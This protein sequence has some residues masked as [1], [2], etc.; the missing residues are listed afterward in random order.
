MSKL[1]L[2]DLIELAKQGYTPDKVKELIELSTAEEAGDSSL[3]EEQPKEQ[4]KEDDEPETKAT[5]VEQKAADSSADIVDYK[6]KVE[7]L[8]KKLLETESRLSDLQKKN[9]RQNADKG[10]QPTDAEVFANAMKSFM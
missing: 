1:K 9:T 5:E 6:K 8:E 3:T 4:P 10:E 7:E 2:T